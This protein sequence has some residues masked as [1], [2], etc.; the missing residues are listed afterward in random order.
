MKPCEFNDLQQSYLPLAFVQDIVIDKV[1]KVLCWHASF[2]ASR[3]T[4]VLKVRN[5]VTLPKVIDFNQGY[6]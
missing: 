6:N 4:R 5:L 3:V 2:Y 1:H